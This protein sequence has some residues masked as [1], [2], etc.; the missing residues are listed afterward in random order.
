MC[1]AVSHAAHAE[2]VGLTGK[3]VIE[4]GSGTG[5]VGLVAAALGA[6]PVI[7]TDLAHLVGPISGNIK[8][9]SGQLSDPTAVTAAELEWGNAAHI[10]SV[11]KQLAVMSRKAGTARSIPQADGTGSTSNEGVL[12]NGGGGKAQYYPDVIIGSDLIYKVN[13]MERLQPRAV[14]SNAS[15]TQSVHSYSFLSHDF[16]CQSST[17]SSS[18]CPS[19]VGTIQL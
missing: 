13:A 6:G 19:F 5:L 8:L 9:N 11:M 7:L 2:D 1:T 15:E 14:V 12:G 17:A 18:P 16:S 10:S 4:I 3:S